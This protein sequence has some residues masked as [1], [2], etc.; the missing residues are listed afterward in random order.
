MSVQSRAIR[1]ACLFFLIMLLLAGISQAAGEPDFGDDTETVL[2]RGRVISVEDVEPDEAVRDFIK[3]EQLA[4]VKITRGQYKGESFVLVNSLMGHPLFDLYLTEGRNVILWGGVDIAGNLRQVYLQDFARDNY[5]YLITGLFILTLLIVG[6]RKGLVTVVTLTI[7]ILAIFR[8]LLPLLLAGYSPIGS[9]IVVAAAVSL[10]TILGLNGLHRKTFAAVTG[11][12]G[13][14]LVAGLLALFIGNAA[15]LTG[16]SS[17][18]AQMLMYMEGG[19]IDVRG[20]LFAGIIIG[21]LGAVMDVAVTISASVYEVYCADRS[22]CV[23]ELVSSAMNVGRD[24][25]GTMANTL[26]L[27]YV[28]TAAP[29]LLLFM[30]YHMP[31]GTIINSDLV[32]TEVV[33]AL[34]G[35]IGLITAIPL[36]AIA[37]GLLLAHGRT[38][39][40]QELKQ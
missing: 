37:S 25:M 5:L 38:P 12:V 31:W 2:L 40:S 39:S 28:G 26:I 19:P 9:T 30:G 35:S 4:T 13:G 34:A 17:E 1:L 24:I 15:N 18:E 3:L 10:V 20:L 8:I 16:F 21:S 36:T 23:R 11:T 27:A 6:R 29:L 14:V 33:R 22:K 32:A 7:T